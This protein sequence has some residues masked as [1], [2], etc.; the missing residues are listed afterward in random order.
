MCNLKA[1][2]SWDKGDPK[3]NGKLKY[4]YSRINFL[5]NPE[6]DSFEDKLRKLLDYLEQDEDGIRHLAKEADGYIQV[7]MHVHNANGMISGP[8]ID[9][10][11]I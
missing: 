2:D 5:P 1:A 11:S 7:A 9:K 3:R 8:A 6:P 4:K 10:D